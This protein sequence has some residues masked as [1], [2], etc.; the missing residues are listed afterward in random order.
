MSNYRNFIIKFHKTLD[1]ITNMM[2]NS[3]VYR[4]TSSGDVYNDT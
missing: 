1:I 3:I 2:Y 4:N